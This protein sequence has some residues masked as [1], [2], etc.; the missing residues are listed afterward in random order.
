MAIKILIVEDESGIVDN[1]TYALK[2]EGFE[3]IWSPTGKE[4]LDTATKEAI[5]L[6]ILDVGL[7]DVNG[8]DLFKDLRKMI[9]AP[10]IF[11]TARSDEVD[12]IVGLEIGADDYVTKPFSPRELAARIKA[13]LRRVKGEKPVDTTSKQTLGHPFQCDEKRKII[14]YFDT[15]LKLSRYEFRIL[16][17]LI[18][19]PGWVY[20]RE[21]LME[22]AWE[23][24]DASLCRTVDSHI[25]NIR[26]KLKK[27]NPDIEPIITHHGSGYS[28]TEEW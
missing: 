14:S 16:N 4:A 11:L 13:V 17:I 26:R 21:K 15:Q 10:V 18:Q 24:P 20:S 25:K 5:D 12:R 6:V 28:L 3:P 23:E 22:M 7:P 9:D 8:F 1:I 27:I 19:H 2:T